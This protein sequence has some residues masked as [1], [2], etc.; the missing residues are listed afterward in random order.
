MCSASDGKL[1]VSVTITIHLRTDES[2][3]CVNFYAV[4]EMVFSGILKTTYIDR[5]IKSIHPAKKIDPC[6]SPSVPMLMVHDAKSEAEKN[7]KMPCRGNKEDSELST[8][9]IR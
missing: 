5:F 7:N 4:N 8:T 3:T 9:P 6:R 1:K 2:G